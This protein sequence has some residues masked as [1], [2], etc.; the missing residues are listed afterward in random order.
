MVT[1]LLLQACLVGPL[2]APVPVSVP[3]LVVLIVAFQAGPG[4]GIGLGFATGLIADLAS[5]QPVGVQ[6]LCWLGAGMAAGLV[7]GLLT[8]HRSTPRSVAVAA[9]GL[10]TLANAAA[11]CLLALLASH[12]TSPAAVAAYLIPASL[13]NAVLALALVRP[14]RA[15]LATLGIWAVAPAGRRIREQMPARV[16]NRM[17]ISVPLKSSR[18]GSGVG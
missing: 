2:C 6:A 15:I 9:A 16:A 17:V 5:P 1:A 10:A 12:G 7:G 3:L 18:T 11:G 4:A 14:V 13:L 8:G